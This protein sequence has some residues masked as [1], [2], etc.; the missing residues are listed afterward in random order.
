VLH[1][2]I[3]PIEW[4]HN[5]SRYVLDVWLNISL[6]VLRGDDGI[7]ATVRSGARRPLQPAHYDV[8]L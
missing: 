8:V 5:H 7:Q 6:I 3:A 4:A 1:R 2:F